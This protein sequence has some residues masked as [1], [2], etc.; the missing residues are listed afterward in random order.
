MDKFPDMSKLVS[1]HWPRRLNI[2]RY[3]NGLNIVTDILNAVGRISVTMDGN[4]TRKGLAVSI[5]LLGI[6]SL[7]KNCQNGSQLVKVQQIYSFAMLKRMWS[8]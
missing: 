8:C 1:C 3:Q 2:Q 7:S 6:V 4:L 5:N